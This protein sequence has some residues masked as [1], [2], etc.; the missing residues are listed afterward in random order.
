[1]RFRAIKGF[2]EKIQRGVV[3]DLIRI[4]DVIQ[5]EFPFS[6]AR[7]NYAWMFI[8]IIC[9]VKSFSVPIRWLTWETRSRLDDMLIN[10]RRCLENIDEVSDLDHFTQFSRIGAKHR[11]SPSSADFIVIVFRLLVRI[12]S[13]AFLAHRFFRLNF[14]SRRRSYDSALRIAIAE[15]WDE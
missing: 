5:W 6:H 3:L 8:D 14:R 4:S 10:N 2:L 15:T 9:V 11:S 7:Y 13:G 12:M 1:M